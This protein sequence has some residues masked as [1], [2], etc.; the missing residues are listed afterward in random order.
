MQPLTEHVPKC[1]LQV[2]DKLVIDHLLDAILERTEGEVVAV[3]GFAAERVRDHLSERYGSRVTTAHNPRFEAD[4]NILSVETG[5]EALRRPQRGYT[6]V[7]TDLL[8]ETSAWDRVFETASSPESFWVCKGRYGRQLTGGI[9]HADAKGQV[10]SV[11]YQPKYDA[12]YEGWPKMVGILS[13]AP[14][15]VSADR[16]YRQAAI[17]DTVAQYYLIPWR[18]HLP[19]LPCRALQIDDCFAQSFNTADDFAD[20]CKQYLALPSTAYPTERP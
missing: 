9:V 6:V 4:V 15:E 8:L 18:N 19:D 7:E 20:T 11:E 17:A 2:G 1:L 16:K 13:V 5:V 14:G 10:T 12:D 3:T